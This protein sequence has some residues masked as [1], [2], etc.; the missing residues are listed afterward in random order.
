MSK[1]LRELILYV[2]R[3]LGLAGAV[4]FVV[5]GLTGS[6]LAFETDFDRWLNPSLWRVRP[7]A[8]RMPEQRLVDLV[9]AQLPLLGLNGHVEQIAVGHDRDAQ[10]FV[11]SGGV[12]LFVNP[13]TGALLGVRNRPS[14]L[15][16][17][18]LS[19]HQFH[20]R[21]LAGN[22]GEWIVDGA[23]ASLLLMI[24]TGVWLWWRKKRLKVKLAA[25]SRR[26][27]WDLHNVFGIY[28]GAFLLL[29]AVT[30]LLVAFETPLYW[31]VR[32][33]PWRP[34]ALPRSTVPSSTDGNLRVP[35][36]DAFMA[37]AN[38]A[39]PGA[40][41]YQIHLPMRPRSPVQVLMH[42]PGL[43]G[44]STVYLD[45]Y[46]GQVLRVEDL[47]KLPRAYR[48]HSINQ[49]IHMGTILGMPTKALLSMSSLVMVVLVITGCLM[50]WQR[51]PD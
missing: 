39:L 14:K 24:P 21:L 44:H 19:V 15:E 30:G 1:K 51:Q 7:E 28:G 8:S 4:L 43:A 23:S 25:S 36:V 13:Y 6:L 46:S 31:M 29:L 16:T 41:T 9:E 12:R 5:M 33:D 45:R 26:I 22:T 40:E 3:Y 48:A 42:G 2:H 18:V 34:G 37:A 50:W 17:F 11:S 27:N 35:D 38:R 32:S 20:V 47:S 10:I 49:A